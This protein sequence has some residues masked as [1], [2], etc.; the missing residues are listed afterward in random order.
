[1]RQELGEVK[2][3][4]AALRRDLPGMLVEAIRAA[5]SA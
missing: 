4:V 2:A 1:M 3:D 5:K